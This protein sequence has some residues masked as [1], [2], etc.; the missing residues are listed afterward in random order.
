MGEDG[1]LT[2]HTPGL[3]EVIATSGDGSGVADTMDI[4]IT[5]VLVSEVE[6]VSPGG[7]SE[8]LSGEDMQLTAT[9]LPANATNPLVAWNVINETGT[10]TITSGGLLTGALPGEVEVVALAMDASGMG[11]TLAVTITDLLVPVNSI[12][13]SAAGGLTEV[14]GGSSLQFTANVL[15]VDA[16]NPLVVWSVINGTGTAA[17]S[18]EGL[19]TAMLAGTVDV[20]ATAEDGSGVSQSYAINITSSAILV[21]DISIL[22]AGAV[23]VMDEEETLQF[24]ATI[25][26]ENASN[27]SITW[28]V[29]PS[30]G[31]ATI[32][33]N[34]L[35]T[36]VS[37]GAVLV[38]A[39]SQD[40]SAVS[41]NFALNINGPNGVFDG[42]GNSPIMLYPNPSAGKFYLEAGTLTLDKLEVYS[43]T[44]ILVREWVPDPGKQRMEIDLSDQHPGAFFIRAISEERSYIHPVIISR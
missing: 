22:S 39:S 21:T 31:S 15:P 16:T 44:G 17:I 13:V 20:V 8:V 9:V 40:G 41:S 25:L 36:A 35:L 37:E 38:M 28:S 14:D 43:M 18:S 4:S 33:Q 26:P 3:V 12:T 29:N 10:A 6:I 32:N 24:S 2:G 11:D 42:R 30:T 5:G 34:G 19:L 27:P 1:L 23:R 7:A